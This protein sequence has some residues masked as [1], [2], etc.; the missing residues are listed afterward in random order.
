MVDDGR[1]RSQR[2]TEQAAPLSPS[3]TAS[4]IS[5]RFPK[6]SAAMVCLPSPIIRCKT[7]AMTLPRDEYA[8]R[9]ERLWEE[10]ERDGVDA[11]FV[12]PSSDLEYLTGIPRDLPS[13]GQTEYAHGW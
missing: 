4:P 11:L 10:L 8:A 1:E 7:G 12:P 5:V 9:R 6:V 2:I 13:F 3:R